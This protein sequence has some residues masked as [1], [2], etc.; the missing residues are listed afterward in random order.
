MPKKEQQ[1]AFYEQ[2]GEV[3][4]SARTYQNINQEVLANAVGISRVSLVNIENGKQRVP[5]HIFLAISR[6]LQIPF[7]RLLPNEKPSRN[8]LYSSI[9]NKIKNEIDNHE[10]SSEIILNYI[11]SIN[12]TKN[13]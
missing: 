8:E 12:S 2:I 3:I 10:D 13:I 5:L 6:Y 7:D 9:I 4:R 11:S 1:S